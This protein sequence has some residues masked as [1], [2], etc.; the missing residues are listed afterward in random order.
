MDDSMNRQRDDDDGGVEEEWRGLT[1][2]DKGRN[3]RGLK[4]REGVKHPRQQSYQPIS[5]SGYMGT[6]RN[7]RSPKLF[8][9]ELGVRV[10]WG[11]L[12]DRE[13]GVGERLMVVLGAIHTFYYTWQASYKKTM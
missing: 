3:R 9:S 2:K 11:G 6:T 1:G 10:G 5:V 12:R 4:D 8:F 13:R 7:V